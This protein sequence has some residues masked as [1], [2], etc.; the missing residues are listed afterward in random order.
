MFLNNMTTKADSVNTY[1]IDYCKTKKG[2]EAKLKKRQKL[3]MNKIKQEFTV[4]AD[5][6]IALVIEIDNEEIIIQEYGSCLFKTCKD[7]EKAKEITQK[8]FKIGVKDD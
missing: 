2:F 7:E 6:G 3:D 4:I 1:S 5:A 8:I